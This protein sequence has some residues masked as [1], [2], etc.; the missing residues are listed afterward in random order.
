MKS[1]NR[2]KNWLTG[3]TIFILAIQTGM[4][5]LPQTNES[6]KLESEIALLTEEIKASQIHQEQTLNLI[7]TS[8]SL[9]LELRELS[10]KVDSAYLVI[11]KLNNKKK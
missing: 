6:P 11:N 5:T 7:Q 10:M 1:N 3:I 8:D 9:K 2:N 4:A